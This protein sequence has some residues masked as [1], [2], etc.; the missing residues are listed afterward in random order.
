MYCEQ[1]GTQIKNGNRFCQKCINITKKNKVISILIISFVIFSITFG[2]ILALV[3][4]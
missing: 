2:S 3:T 1:C 4:G